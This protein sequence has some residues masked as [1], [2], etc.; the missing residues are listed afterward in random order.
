MCEKK[1]AIAQQLKVHK[2]VHTGE[3]NYLCSDCGNSYGSQSTLIDHRYVKKMLSKY[4]KFK[5]EF[6]EKKTFKTFPP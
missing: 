6:Q 2:A 3:K 5:N 1:F 4:V